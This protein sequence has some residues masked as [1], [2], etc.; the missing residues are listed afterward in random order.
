[1][2]DRTGGGVGW[3]FFRK[4]RF[5]RMVGTFFSSE[6]N[7]ASTDTGGRALKNS[8]KPSPGTTSACDCLSPAGYPGD[9]P[10]C[11]ALGISRLVAS[12]P[13]AA[14]A[15]LDSAKVPEPPVIRVD[16]RYG[17]DQQP[18]DG[19]GR[20]PACDEEVL[21]VAHHDATLS[22]LG[23]YLAEVCPTVTGLVRPTRPAAYRPPSGR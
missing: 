14:I 5:V 20:A 9:H 10:A 22:G 4:S 8:T 13:T 17:D 23:S 2:A 16:H 21:I 19:S 7:M 15:R 12:R 1:M 11:L 18:Q 6:L 3:A